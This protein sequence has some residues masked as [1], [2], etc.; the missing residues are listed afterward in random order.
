MLPIELPHPAELQLNQAN[1]SDTDAPFLD[2]DL[3]ISNGTVSTKSY[4]KRDDFDFDIVNFLFLD[5]DVPRRTSKNA[6]E[7]VQSWNVFET[8]ETSEARICLAFV[9]YS[10][11]TMTVFELTAATSVI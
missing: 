4:D 8:T 9:S 1:S 3:S 5:G 11:Y 6:F 10:L 2:I 7:C